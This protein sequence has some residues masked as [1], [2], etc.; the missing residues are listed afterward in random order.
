VHLDLW[1]VDAFANR[2]FAG[3]P[4][5]VC[6]LDSWLDDG[7][8]RSVAEENNLSATAY[9][10]RQHDEYH[11]R[12]FTPQCEIKLC[13]HATLA[14]GFLVLN[15]LHPS[16]DTV[17]FETRFSGPLT[18]RREGSLFAMDFPAFSPRPCLNPPQN[19]LHAL[20]MDAPPMAVFEANSTYF[21][22][23]DSEDAVQKLRPNLA[24]IEKLHPFVVA[25]TA[26]GETCDF[27]SRYFAR[28]YGVPE[29]PV[30]GSAHCALAPYWAQ[31]LGKANLHA[32]QVSARGGELWC[33][34][35][36]QRVTIKG[37]VV[38]TLQGSLLL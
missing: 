38:L 10:V 3:N 6:L 37:N 20:G 14:T 23:C 36:G 7:L 19:L 16:R 1:H 5:A 22:V 35:G 11:L 33:E 31:R 15:I 26:P 29:D 13:G 12:W 8:L 27:V 25:V 2:P 17:R 18:V 24:L 28:S 4:A 34:L 32:R 21:V 9:L 30:T